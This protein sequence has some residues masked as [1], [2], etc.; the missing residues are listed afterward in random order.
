MM[1]QA[2]LLSSFSYS[3]SLG[4]LLPLPAVLLIAQLAQLRG[5][6]LSGFRASAKL[7]EL[8]ELA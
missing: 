1:I 5:S 8:F 6:E 7:S 4:T 3:I 2:D